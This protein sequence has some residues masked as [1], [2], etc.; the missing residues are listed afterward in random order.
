[1]THSKSSPNNV[2]AVITVGN[3]ENGYQNI[4]SFSFSPFS[5]CSAWREQLFHL[6]AIHKQCTHKLILTLLM[7]FVNINI[8]SYLV[9]HQSKP[10]FSMNVQPC[11]HIR[12]PH[13]TP[14]NASTAVVVHWSE[15]TESPTL[16]AEVCQHSEQLFQPNSVLSSINFPCLLSFCRFHENQAC[17]SVNH[18]HSFLLNDDGCLAFSSINTHA[19]NAFVVQMHLDQV[20]RHFHLQ[21]LIPKSTADVGLLTRF[22]YIDDIT[23]LK[24]KK[25]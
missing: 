13:S 7:M 8:N 16:I 22:P 20:I 12:A 21:S 25:I 4:S 18:P 24:K 19:N 3:T 11:F 1:M 6:K 17:F 9:T 10:N 2:D 15:H 5:Q 23:K 14:T